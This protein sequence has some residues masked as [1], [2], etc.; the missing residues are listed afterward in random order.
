MSTAVDTIRECV[1]AEAVTAMA[2]GAIL[3][4]VRDGAEVAVV[5]IPDAVSAPMCS[6]VE[7]V[8]VTVADRDHPVLVICASGSRSRR[9]A[10]SLNAAGFGNVHSVKGGIVAWE[11]HGL[12]TM[13]SGRKHDGIALTPDQVDRYARHLALPSIGAAGQQRMCNARVLVIGAGGL[14]CPAL[15]YLAAAGIGTIGVADDDVVDRSNLQRQV[16]H[17][18]DR[19]GSSKVDSVRA[20]LNALNPDIEIVG[21]NT[22][23]DAQTIAALLDSRW[24]VI[25]DCVDSLDTRYAVNDAAVTRGIPVVHGAAASFEG[26]L[27]VLGHDGGPCYRCIWPEPVSAGLAPNCATAGVLGVVPG[28]IGVMQ[29]GEV[30]KLVTGVGE[31]LSGTLVVYD[32]LSTELNRFA[33]RRNPACPTCS[34][35]ERGQ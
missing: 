34:T 6:T 5:S 29:A 11:A 18:D 12:P 33:V 22:R 28:A 21:Y 4:D 16:A 31:P 19:V 2:A 13:R 10:A 3:I 24:D 17:T 20:S 15:M 8:A 14:G 23:V 35:L 32:A 26:R 30:L 7:V 25:V 1:P 9:A 27:T